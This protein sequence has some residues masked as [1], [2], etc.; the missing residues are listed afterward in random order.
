MRALAVRHGAT[1]WNTERLVIGQCDP[2]LN[3][4]GRADAANISH[5]L[6]AEQIST[7]WT[8]DL[9]RAVETAITIAA[10]RQI[11]ISRMS[12]L[13]EPSFGLLEGIAIKKLEQC[14]EWGIRESDKYAYLPPGGESCFMVEERIKPILKALFG[15]QDRLPLL[16]THI[17]VLRVLFRLLNGC[18]PGDAALLRPLHS[19]IWIIE[20]DER[21]SCMRLFDQ[22]RTPAYVLAI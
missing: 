15:Q 2:P 7:I 3:K 13:R 1:D 4:F 5:R 9:R 17:G 10:G 6:A 11:Q 12:A 22:S 14:G 20:A 21:N 16:V 8:S 18:S 19:D